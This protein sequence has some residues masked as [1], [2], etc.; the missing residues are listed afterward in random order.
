MR[1]ELAP[2]AGRHHILEH[3]AEDGGADAGPV[4]ATRGQQVGPYFRI[5]D[6]HGERGRIGEEVA[7]DVGEGGE[8]VIEASGASLGRR[9]QN[10][11]EK[12][13]ARPEVCAVGG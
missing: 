8:V 4:E 13:K 11:E 9:V 10:L 3:G 5:A 12:C 7:V 6:G 2:L 1:P